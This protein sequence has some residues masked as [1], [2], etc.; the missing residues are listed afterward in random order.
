MALQWC[1]ARSLGRELVSFLSF[2]VDFY[3]RIAA[4][5]RM[6]GPYGNRGSS[7]SREQTIANGACLFWCTN[8]TYRLAAS[9]KIQSIANVL[10][11]SEVV[12][13]AATRLYTLAVEHKFTKGRK[14]MNVVAVCLYVACRQKET[15][16]YMLIDFSDLLQVN[17]FELGHT[18]LQLV[19]TLNLRLPLVDPSHYISRFAAL[20]EFGDETSKVATDAVRLVQRFDRDWMTRGRRPAG[21]CGAALLLAARMNNFRRSVEEIVQVVKIADT[22]LKKR[23]DE[24]K[25]TPSGALTLADFR[26][27]WLEEEMDPPAFTKGK[28]RE[29]AERLAVEARGNGELFE[30]GEEEWMNKMKKAKSKKGKKRKGKRKR[31]GSDEEEEDAAANGD[32]TE[33]APARQTID[34]SVLA[35]SIVRDALDLRLEPPPIDDDNANIDPAL[36]EQSISDLPLPSLSNLSDPDL[37][38]ATLTSLIPPPTNIIDE[39]VS[40]ALAEEVSGFLNNS[41]GTQLTDAL[42]EAEERRLAQME[43][44]DE[45]LGLNEDELDRFILSEEEVKIKERVWVELNKDYLEAL[46]GEC[47]GV[48]CMVP[49][50]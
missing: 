28:E 8:L 35:D 37:S 45:L 36:L 29:E 26:N 48:V 30:E 49:F 44:V 50:L 41:Q 40:Q 3:L 23:L 25:A 7:E 15:R 47:H 38:A 2:L 34:P 18:Y 10:R 27:V 9:K 13:L 19:Q 14:S 39:T 24:F 46:A 6:S 43:V 20:L 21:I 17:V 16:N 32:M 12:C 33:E 4:H 22:T 11:L 5:A 31:G 42:D 1:R